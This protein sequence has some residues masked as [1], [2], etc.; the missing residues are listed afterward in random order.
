MFNERHIEQNDLKNKEIAQ[1]YISGEWTVA[2]DAESRRKEIED[3]LHAAIDT[4]VQDLPVHMHLFHLTKLDVQLEGDSERLSES[5]IED[6]A[7]I[8]QNNT[9]FNKTSIW[10]LMPM[11]PRLLTPIS[12]VVPKTTE[13]HGKLEDRT[14]HYTGAAYEFDELYYLLNNPDVAKMIVAGQYR[15]ELIISG[16]RVAQRADPKSKSN[17]RVAR[18]NC[19]ENEITKARELPTETRRKRRRF[20]Y[21]R[22][23]C[24]RRRQV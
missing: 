10:L 15:S 4:A 19:H 5:D 13:S 16:R 21:T 7:A 14:H 1:R 2:T 6:L 22:L 24:P 9:S 20:I 8:A 23:E 3:D 12:S 17:P 11:L 18:S